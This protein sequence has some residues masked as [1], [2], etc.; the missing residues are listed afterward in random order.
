MVTRALFS[1]EYKREQM[2][3]TFVKKIIVYFS[4][5]FFF[6][7]I[8]LNDRLSMEIISANSAVV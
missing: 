3:L 1:M 2:P 6:F 8:E 5:S 4:G 7:L